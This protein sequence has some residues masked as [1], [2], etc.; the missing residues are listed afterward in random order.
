LRL[1]NE[2]AASRGKPP[3]KDD[4]KDDTRFFG[5]AGQVLVSGLSKEELVAFM[6]EIPPRPEGEGRL[7]PSQR[8]GFLRR[9][10]GRR[11]S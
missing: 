7:V 6:D 4:A 9:L 2:L 5:F 1:I 8:R 11:L 10:F 3:L